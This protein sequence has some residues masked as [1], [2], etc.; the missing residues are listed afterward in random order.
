MFFT[1]NVKHKLQQDTYIQRARMFGARG[2]F[3]RHFEL[4]I[5]AQL[6][7]DW[8]R[9]FVLH[10][11]ALETINNKLGSP[12]WIGDNRVSVVAKSSIDNANVVLDK[13]E[14]S[15]GMFDYAPDLDS[16]V[17]ED[18]GNIETLRKLQT[19]IGKE[20]LPGFLIEYIKATSLSGSG[21]FAVHTA[22][23]IA[24][25]RDADQTAISRE[26]GFMG[27]SQLEPKKFTSAVH[28]VKIFLH[29]EG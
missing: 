20:A 22:S 29:R 16:V 28:H 7:T 23:S 17:L 12:V 19:R 15:F 10:K 13:G 8:H 5:P 11:L 6:Y 26:K 14:M 21:L 4:T 3:L 1:R 9:C 27:K 2:E 24:G 18:Q 25:S